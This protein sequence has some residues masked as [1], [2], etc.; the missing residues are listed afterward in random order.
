MKIILVLSTILLCLFFPSCGPVDHTLS[1]NGTPMVDIDGRNVPMAHIEDILTNWVLSRSD[2]ISRS[3]AKEIVKESMWVDYPM[4]MLAI[5]EVESNFVP[6]AISSK[7]A[8]GLTQIMPKI[9]G[10]ALI[11][12]NII[13][14]HRD[15]FDIAISIR[16]G[17]IVLRDC[18]KQSKGNISNALEQYLGGKDG[19]YVKA[20]LTNL[21]TLYILTR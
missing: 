8:V 7:G 12:S 21:A 1:V 17:N 16:A 14:E 15:L 3:A 5:I 19:A 4:L 6:T 9:H 11:K 2:R 18:L 10:P 20:I 13:K